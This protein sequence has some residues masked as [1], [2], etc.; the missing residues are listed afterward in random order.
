MSVKFSVGFRVG[1]EPQPD[2]SGHNVPVV[3]LVVFGLLVVVCLLAVRVEVGKRPGGS[4]HEMPLVFQSLLRLFL[5]A[6]YYGATKIGRATGLCRSWQCFSLTMVRYKF[7]MGLLK[8][9]Q[10]GLYLAVAVAGAE[11]EAWVAFIAINSKPGFSS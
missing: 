8:G 1:A 2:G 5:V 10:W 6:Q 9:S 4:G 11:Q 7:L 3:P